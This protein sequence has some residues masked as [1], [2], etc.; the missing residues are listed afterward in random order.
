MR[1]SETR[2][3]RIVHLTTVHRPDD[4][5]IFRKECRTL[6]AAGYEVVLVAPGAPEGVVDGVRFH[7][8]RR[9]KSRF[10]RFAIGSLEIL[11]AALIEA[12]ALYHFHDPELMPVGAVLRLLGR[13]VIQ[14][15]HEDL[16]GQIRSKHWIPRPL[17]GA[18]AGLARGCQW[19]GSR[20]FTAVVVAG[21][22]IA[23][24]VSSRGVTVVRNYPLLEEFPSVRRTP[25]RDRPMDIAY[26]GGMARRRAGR[27]LIEA[28]AL[29]PAEIGTRLL[30][31]GSFA[32]DGLESEVRQLPGWNRTTLLGWLS[33]S[34]VASLLSRVRV[35]L[36]M[37][38]P[39]P[40]HLAVRSN[41]VFEYMAA[42]VPVVAPDFPAWKELL[43]SAGCG[44][45][46]DPSDPHAIAS[47]VKDL[48]IDPD[49][50]EV[51]AQRGHAAVLERYNWE[52]E[53]VQ[54]ISLYQRILGNAAGERAVP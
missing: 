40:N 39:E 9:H 18:A 21:H 45:P 29:V 13:R 2:R 46:V 49:Q 51:M 23:D 16:P 22:D 35:G 47:A 5:R 20:I 54:L 50:A 6:A 8:I 26:L 48:L 31:A 52:A 41:K 36:V 28:M 25:L 4:V 11:R 53:S 15:I 30:I 1:R 32:D 38:S 17:R 44:I 37:F 19:V 43:A 42:G 12:G 34:E 10:S 33:R 14:D 27:E 24:T 3:L 7:S